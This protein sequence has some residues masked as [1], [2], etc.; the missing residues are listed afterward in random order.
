MFFFCRSNLGERSRAPLLF[1][2]LK[3]RRRGPIRSFFIP[4][5]FFDHRLLQNAAFDDAHGPTPGDDDNDARE[6]VAL[7]REEHVAPDDDFARSV[8]IVAVIVA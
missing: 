6:S 4:L 5:F 2:L 1:L 3:R 8:A 7:R